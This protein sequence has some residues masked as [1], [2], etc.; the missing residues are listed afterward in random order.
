M[1][2]ELRC[3]WLATFTLQ[4]PDF[5]EVCLFR[6]VFGDFVSY[7]EVRD[8][9]DFTWLHFGPDKVEELVEELRRRGYTET[10]NTECYIET[11]EE[12][13]ERL[14]RRIEEVYGEGYLG[15]KW[16]IKLFEMLE[17]QKR[18][19]GWPWAGIIGIWFERLGIWRGLLSWEQET[20]AELIVKHI[21][22]E[23]QKQEQEE[24]VLW[25][26]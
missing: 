9:G 5:R 17:H 13:V 7:L 10:W 14:R 4:S 8:G 15:D 24:E 11:V 19:Y 26:S 12:W 6:L 21:E 1:E 23:K 16:A 2:K 22:R 20:L 25:N 18:Y 3:Q